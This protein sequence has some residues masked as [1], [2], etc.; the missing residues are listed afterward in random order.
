MEEDKYMMRAVDIHLSFAGVMALQN[1]KIHLAPSELLA[2]IGPKGT[3]KSSL[4]NCFNGFYR[5]PSV[6]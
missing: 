4:L 6:G 5:R 2:I 3:G 1:V